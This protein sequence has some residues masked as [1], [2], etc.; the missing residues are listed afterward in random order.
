MAIA[1]AAKRARGSSTDHDEIYQEQLNQ[2]NERGYYLDPTTKK[3]IIANLYRKEVLENKLGLKNDLSISCLGDDVEYRN[4]K[5]PNYF[6]MTSLFQKMH[7]DA[8]RLYKNENPE[9][10][11]DQLLNE[12][13]NKDPESYLRI[14]N[15]AIWWLFNLS[16]THQYYD[17][18]LFNKKYTLADSYM[19]E[20]FKQLNTRFFQATRIGST[21]SAHFGQHNYKYDICDLHKFTLPVAKTFCPMEYLFFCEFIGAKSEA[22]DLKRAFSKDP[23]LMKQARHV[24]HFSFFRDKLDECGFKFV[25]EFYEQYVDYIVTCMPQYKNYKSCFLTAPH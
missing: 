19:T 21:A 24:T 3:V 22:D 2:F 8:W 5:D 9:F 25:S 14:Q 15:S 13:K 18:S 4:Q 12:I 16:E 6:K 20:R 23:E 10:T 1:P 17:F 11:D 7:P